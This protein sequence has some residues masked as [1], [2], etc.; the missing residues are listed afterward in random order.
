M[1]F[2]EDL[3]YKIPVPNGI[4]TVKTYHKEI[5][6][7]LNGVSGS[8][9]KRVFDIKVENET[10]YSELDL[11]NLSGNESVVLTHENIEVKDGY[12]DLTLSASSN[13][14]IISAFSIEEKGLAIEVPIPDL[15][16]AKYINAGGS[17]D[18]IHE[19]N[20]FVSDYTTKYY[21]SSGTS[22]NKTASSS[23]I[24][25]TIRFAENLIYK[26]PVE[27][28]VYRVKTYHIENY[29]GVKNPDGKT[30]MRVFDIFLQNELVKNDLDL[31]A[32][33]GNQETNLIFNDIL[34]KDGELKIELKASVNNALIAG[35]AII[36]MSGFYDDL[37]TD[38]FF[39]NVGSDT[40]TDYQGINFV[41]EDSKIQIPSNSYPYNVPTSSSDKL[42]QSNRYG[43]SLNYQFPVSNGEYTVITYHNENY[44]GEITSK[45]G[46]NNRVFDINIEN[47]TVKSK[48]DLYIENSNRPVTLR[49]DNITVSDG[50]LNLDFEGIENNALVSGIAVFPSEKINL[51]NTN[52]RQLD[53]E[54]EEMSS[55]NETREDNFNSALKNKI[56]PNPA[57][58]Y[59]ILQ[60]G[61]D[62]GDFYISIHN[63]NGQLI[64]FVKAEDI[65]NS[66]GNYEIPVQNLRQGV[67]IVTLTSDTGVLERMR[68][69]V[70]PKY[71]FHYN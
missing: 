58:S 11:Y 41:S 56:Y 26:I 47:T 50:I 64:S 51:G 68:L 54:T 10:K 27:N 3:Y 32:R 43:K 30:G 21:S 35:I 12:L 65:Q 52:L 22:E 48:V 44:F 37:E 61:E 66:D 29:F 17:E 5:H 31:Y 36:P 38:S 57:I 49:F 2:N 42:F 70:T 18:G 9:G 14:A 25:Q 69:A 60:T 6:F 67:Y 1:E 28:G 15:K 59:A 23:P 33:S 24:F 45:T 63:F 7:G 39:I 62:L 71:S 40:D 34:V 4:Y 55:M 20:V 16:G 8:K 13:N 19:G 53:T 46:E